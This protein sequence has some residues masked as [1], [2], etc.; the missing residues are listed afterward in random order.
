LAVVYLK[1]P[2]KH[3]SLIALL[4]IAFG[5]SNQ[6]QTLDYLGIQDDEVSDLFMA[7]EL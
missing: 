1:R 3:E 7:L 6:K 2:K 4:M 5:H